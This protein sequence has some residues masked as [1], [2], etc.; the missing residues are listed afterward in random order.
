MQNLQIGL[1]AKFAIS[2]E[3]NICIKARRKKMHFGEGAKF[4]RKPE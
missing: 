3:C 1:V 4:A 2:P